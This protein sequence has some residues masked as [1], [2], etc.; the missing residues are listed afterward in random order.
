M[1]HFRMH[2]HCCHGCNLPPKFKSEMQQAENHEWRIVGP[3]K[4]QKGR[5][6]FIEMFR[7][8]FS[9]FGVTSCNVNHIQSQHFDFTMDL[10]D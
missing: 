5:I 3:S 4:S 10:E 2:K 9:N 7:R 8:C 1:V 6:P